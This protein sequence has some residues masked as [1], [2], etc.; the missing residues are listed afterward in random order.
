MRTQTPPLGPDQLF[1]AS[2]ETCVPENP[3]RSRWCP[4]PTL[5]SDLF[6]GMWVPYVVQPEA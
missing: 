4:G 5:S 1:F 2:Q 3:L 6:S